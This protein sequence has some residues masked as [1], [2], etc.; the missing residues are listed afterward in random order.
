MSS[1]SGRGESPNPLDIT[2]EAREFFYWRDRALMG[3]KDQLKKLNGRMDKIEG[4]MPPL[5]EQNQQIGEGMA[6]SQILAKSQEETED[7]KDNMPPL[8]ECGDDLEILLSGRVLQACEEF[9]SRMNHSE[10]GNDMNNMEAIQPA[11]Q[12]I[13]HMDQKEHIEDIGSHEDELKLDRP[14]LNHGDNA[15]KLHQSPITIQHT[16]KFQDVLQDFMKT[17]WA[18]HA[19]EDSK[20]F[21]GFCGSEIEA[22]WALFNILAVHVFYDYG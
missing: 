14:Y 2:L 3:I 4:I 18:N 11:I 6:E 21:N 9:D 8:Q 1:T 5:E 19:H 22:K 17:V 7:S 20:R 10:R 15:L 16:K 13:I 12:L